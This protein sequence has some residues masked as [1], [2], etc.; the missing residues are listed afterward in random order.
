MSPPQKVQT[1]YVKL[2]QKESQPSVSPIVVEAP[3]VLLSAM[4]TEL[5]AAEERAGHQIPRKPNSSNKSAD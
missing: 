1:R 4:L 3:V 5:F 2:N